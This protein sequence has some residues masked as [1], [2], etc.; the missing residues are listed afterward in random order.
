MVEEVI[1]YFEEMVRLKNS[2]VPIDWQ[3]VAAAMA[4]TLRQI[5]KDN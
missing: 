5:P 4:S 3:G 1:K 2:G